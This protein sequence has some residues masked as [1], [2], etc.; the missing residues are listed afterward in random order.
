MYN[1]DVLDAM[2]SDRLLK[3]DE[4]LTMAQAMFALQH[5]LVSCYIDPVSEKMKITSKSPSLAKRMGI[6]LQD[7]GVLEEEIQPKKT[8]IKNSVLK[9]TDS[10]DTEEIFDALLNAIDQVLDDRA[11]N[12][13]KM[14]AQALINS[15]SKEMPPLT[16]EDLD[17]AASAIETLLSEVCDIANKESNKNTEDQKVC[18]S[19]IEFLS[20]L[21][22]F[23]YEMMDEDENEDEEDNNEELDF[24]AECDNKDIN[25]LEF[26]K[27][28]FDDT[29]SDKHTK[30]ETKEP[31]NAIDAFMESFNFDVASDDM[32]YLI[33][34]LSEMYMNAAENEWIEVVAAIEAILELINDVPEGTNATN[35]AWTETILPAY[36]YVKDLYWNYDYAECEKFDDE[37]DDDEDDDD[38]SNY[39]DYDRCYSAYSEQ[40]NTTHKQ[41]QPDTK[42]TAAAPKHPTTDAELLKDLKEVLEGGTPEE[43]DSILQDAIDVKD[44]IDQAVEIIN[45]ATK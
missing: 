37:C 15:K 5:N 25:Y 27:E 11:K 19:L 17:V 1:S 6:F 42:Q 7:S 44:F 29:D 16:Q 41:E 26:L 9:E 20:T 8:M 28:I 34:L 10:Q 21:L 22:D 38:R 24:D 18:D 23:T 13:D 30:T 4:P 32:I 14:A 40:S 43:I 12:G 31:S 45:N 3:S 35:F 39:S 2:L 36:E 33:H